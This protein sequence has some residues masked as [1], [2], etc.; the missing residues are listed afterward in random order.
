MH[1]RRPFPDSHKTTIHFTALDVKGRF[2]YPIL[3]YEPHLNS[4]VLSH[5]L[6]FVKNALSWGSTEISNVTSRA[7]PKVQN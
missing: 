6:N 1:S 7:V 4:V 5:N 2:I 3:I